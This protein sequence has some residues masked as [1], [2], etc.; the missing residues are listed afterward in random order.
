[1]L[2]A[3][4]T[5]ELQSRLIQVERAVELLQVDSYQAEVDEKWAGAIATTISSL[6]EIPNACIR[7]GSLLIIKYTTSGGP[8]IL[9]RQLTQAE[10]A[11]IEKLP[12]L[13]INPQNVLAALAL[14]MGRKDTSDSLG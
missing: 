3:F 5:S 13:Q 9:V 6:Q 2:G 12:E 8:K 10:I 14:A 7:V 4:T 11:T 1:M